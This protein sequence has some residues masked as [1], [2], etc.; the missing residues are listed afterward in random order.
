[1][2]TTRTREERAGLLAAAEPASLCALADQC[3]HGAPDPEVTLPPEVGMVV[4]TVRE[5][6]ETIRFHLG[7]VLVTRCEVRHRGQLGW[8]M[9]MGDDPPATLAAAVLDA[10]AEADGP[11]RAEV[12]ALCNEVARQRAEV[13]AREWREVAPTIVDFEEME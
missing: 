2:T 3:L 1:M 8:C 5:P 7:E 10:E 12:E 9:R 6:V 4:L 11:H 13:D